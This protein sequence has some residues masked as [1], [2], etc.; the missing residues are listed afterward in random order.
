ML[1]DLA[2]RRNIVHRGRQADIE[3]GLGRDPRERNARIRKPVEN[4]GM[5]GRRRREDDAVQRRGPD[6][7][8]HFERAVHDRFDRQN[9]QPVAS[10]MQSFER[11]PLQFDDIART[12]LFVD[13]ADKIGLSPDKALRKNIGMVVELLRRTEHLFAQCGRDMRFVVE[14]ARHA[15]G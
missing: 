5:I 2:R 10:A 8:D 4:V 9:D 7:T 6:E 1:R 14:D 13:Q 12:R 11:A 3:P 15:F